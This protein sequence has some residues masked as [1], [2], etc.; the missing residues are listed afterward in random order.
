MALACNTKVINLQVEIEERDHHYRLLWKEIDSSR[1]PDVY[2]FSRVMFGKNYAT[3]EAQFGAL[4]NAIRHQDM[5][6]LAALN[7]T[8]MDNSIDS[9]K[10]AQN[11]IQ[12]YKELGNLC[13][14]AG[15]ETGKWVSNCLEAVAATPESYSATEVPITVGQ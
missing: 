5:Y 9:V 4:E 2:K 11:I 15:M 1:K 3:M 12:L 10:T 7:S 13:G 14:I 6:P 8:Y